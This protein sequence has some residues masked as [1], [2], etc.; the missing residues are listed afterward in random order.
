MNISV[1]C[2]IFL[3]CLC[4]NIIFAQITSIKIMRLSFL[5]K[6]I[7]LFLIYSLEKEENLYEFI[8]RFNKQEDG[9]LNSY[10]INDFGL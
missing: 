2:I 6:K 5:V 8:R 10:T 3:I 9:L 1:E 4:R 7:T